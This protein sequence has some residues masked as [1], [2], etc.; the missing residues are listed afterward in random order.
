MR[1]QPFPCSHVP[2]AGRLNSFS[3]LSSVRHRTVAVLGDRQLLRHSK[4]LV[5]PL[6]L[7]RS[8]ERRYPF[9]MAA[10]GDC[11]RSPGRSAVRATRCARS[12][13]VCA[14]HPMCRKRCRIRCGRCRSIG[15]RSSTISWLGHPLKFLWEENRFVRSVDGTLVSCRVHVLPRTVFN[16]ELIPAMVGYI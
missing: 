7:R 16:F 13:T 14:T 5:W 2:M 9:L 3:M 1:R 12:A 11:A 10:R 8:R 6:I 4:P 15:H